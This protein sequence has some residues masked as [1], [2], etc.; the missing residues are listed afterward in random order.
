[1]MGENPNDG[2]NLCQELSLAKVAMPYNVA[3]TLVTT[4]QS[5][6]T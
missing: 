3:I 5:V 4:T 1:M 2:S 6:F